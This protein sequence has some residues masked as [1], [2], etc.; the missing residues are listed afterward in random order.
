MGAMP[1]G[2]APPSPTFRFHDAIASLKV[3]VYPEIRHPIA[4]VSYVYCS[5]TL[6]R[7]AG[8]RDKTAVDKK[9]HVL[10]DFT[11]ALILTYRMT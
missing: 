9:S 7:F 1:M 2:M 6:C 4:Q 11:M 3:G 5:A 10:L 8:A